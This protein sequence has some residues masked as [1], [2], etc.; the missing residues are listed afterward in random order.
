MPSTVLERKLLI[1]DTQ[2]IELQFSVAQ[3]SGPSACNHACRET[4]RVKALAVKMRK[5][6]GREHKDERVMKEYESNIPSTF[7]KPTVRI[8]PWNYLSE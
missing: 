1:H 8:N 4:G 7:K 2:I 5:G 6:V 3:H